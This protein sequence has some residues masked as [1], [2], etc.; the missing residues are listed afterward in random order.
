MRSF[1]GRFPAGSLLFGR[2]HQ[3]SPCGKYGP[4]ACAEDLSGEEFAERTFGRQPDLLLCGREVGDDGHRVAPGA[5]REAEYAVGQAPFG[6]IACFGSPFAGGQCRVFV[7]QAGQRRVELPEFVFAPLRH[8]VFL[9]EGEAVVVADLL[10]GVDERHA[11][12]QGEGEQGHD[13]RGIAHAFE[14]APGPRVLVVV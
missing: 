8:G 6:R 1:G 5:A 12:G 4:A 9:E 7:A 3:P 11:L 10:S 2:E 13:A 14:L